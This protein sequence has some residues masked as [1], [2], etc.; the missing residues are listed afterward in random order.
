VEEIKT[1]P[2]SVVQPY[3]PKPP[4]ST[5]RKKGSK[6]KLTLLR[7]AVLNKQEEMILNELPKIV[8]V[9]CRK[10]AEGDLTAAKLILERIIPVKK[11][12]DGME[13]AKGPPVIT[14]NIEGA[15]ARLSLAD[16]RSI[17]IATP[18]IVDGD[19]QSV[20]DDDEVEEEEN[21]DE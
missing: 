7:E 12:S 1:I 18:V 5:G 6:N 9:V 20:S 17:Q 19:F 15:D 2:T 10:A 16:P 3:K 8:E 21:E 4:P 11:Q 14:I 13:A